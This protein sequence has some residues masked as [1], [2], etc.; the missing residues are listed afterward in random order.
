MKNFAVVDNNKVINVII[1]DD[2]FAQMFTASPDHIGECFEYSTSNEDDTLVARIG[3]SYINGKFITPP[4]IVSQS[5]TR[6]QAMKAMKNSGIWETFK[7]VL[8]SNQDAQD[9]WDLTTELKHDNEF[10]QTLIP[11]LNLTTEQFDELF[12]KASLL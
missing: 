7:T 2:D 8:A 5:I 1:A 4:P 12:N 11:M 6:I 10:V 3:D 9:E